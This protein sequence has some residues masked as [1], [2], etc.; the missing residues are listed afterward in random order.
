[1]RHILNPQRQLG[2]TDIGAIQFDPYSRDDIP[3]ILK[4]LQ[5]IYTNSAICEE[6]FNHLARIIP[7]GIDAG[8][9]RPGMAL[10]DIFVL[11]TLRLN[12]N[13][14][15][16]RLMELANEHRTLRE[17]LG[18]AL[19]DENDQYRLQT[20]KDN[21]SLLTQEVLDDINQIVVRGGHALLGKADEP[22]A[23]RCDSAVVETDVHFP[24]D[25]SLLTDAIR[26]VIGLCGQAG[27]MFG[28]LGWRQY[29][30]NFQCF[31]NLYRKTVKLKRSTSKDEAKVEA[32]K[33]RI[34]EAHQ[35]FMERSE[36]YL[37]R[38][39]ATVK[40]LQKIEL[41]G[42]IVEEIKHYIA[43]AERQ[44]DQIR[45]RVIEGEKIAHEEKVF[46][47]FE[48]HT[49]WIS[50]GK[51]GVPV[52]L[53][54]RVCV[55]EDTMGFIL[56]HQVMEQ[57]TDDKVAVSIIEQTQARFP[58][59]RL[60]SFDKGFYTPKN[61]EVLQERLEKVVLPKKG[62][63]SKK[64]REIETEEEFVA[65]RKRHSSVE[66]AIN[67]LEVHGLDRC[68]DHGIEGF[69]RYIALAIVARNIQKIGAILQQRARAAARRKACTVKRAA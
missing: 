48:E 8:N 54:L 10:W 39:K 44:I 34:K 24:T 18:H 33:S 57:Q 38:A 47:V 6:V 43:H 22:L 40:E 16:D 55:L 12:L 56:H 13:C 14:D 37:E 60:C 2:E 64:D 67:A 58:K 62:K 25:T 21:V 31:K 7:E 26:K 42:A 29:Q 20:I 65:A 15:Y 4:G 68:P 66:S 3:Q 41:A 30:Y 46:S 50:K 52:E 61:R 36:Y 17:M 23:G 63:W 32:R 69:K 27:E 1:M 28:V 11:G 59:L 53:G 49:E 45:R 9:G 35:A 5:Y 19:V 51:A